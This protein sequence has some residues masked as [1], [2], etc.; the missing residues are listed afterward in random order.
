[1]NATTNHWKTVNENAILSVLDTA[2]LAEYGTQSEWHFTGRIKFDG[3][4]W[5]AECSDGDVLTLPYKPE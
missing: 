4:G 5:V 1:M 3:A 2:T